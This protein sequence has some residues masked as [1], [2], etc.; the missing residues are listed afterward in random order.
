MGLAF[1]QDYF[2]L[3]VG[4]TWIYQA[5]GSIRTEPWTV[6]ISGTQTI[7]G[8]EY[9]KVDGFPGVQ[10]LRKNDAGTLILYDE[11]A[12]KE[13]TWVPFSAATGEAWRTEIDDCNN[14]GVITGRNTAI[15]VPA[16]SFRD[17][18]RVAYS[19]TRCADAGLT[20]ETFLPGIG[21]AERRETSFTGERIYALTYA[22]V[23]DTVQVGGREWGFTV[24]LNEANYTVGQ[25]IVARLS[26]RNTKGKPVKLVFPSGQ[27]YDIQ[28]RDTRGQVV[29]TWS[30]SRS[31]L[32]AIREVEINGEKNWLVRLDM[33]SD[34]LNLP[35]GS[36]TLNGTLAVSGGRIEAT[37]PFTVAQVQAQTGIT[38][39][40]LQNK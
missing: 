37:V 3:Q 25:S 14:T 12:K 7:N 19:M 35:P 9:F 36:Y 11:G 30:A 10:Y 2:P 39:T 27:D 20:N 18:L 8:Q 40:Q 21:L 23:N 29:Y 6:E 5:G 38:S 24:A 22:R 13:K 1:G 33:G 15:N 34:G 4:N 32:Q 31:F 16:G 26:L 28:I 17:G